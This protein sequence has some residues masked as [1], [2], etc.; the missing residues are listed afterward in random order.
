MKC[1]DSIVNDLLRA[2]GLPNAKHKK[3]KELSMGMKQRLGVAKALMG[4]PNL[5]L[6][7]EPANG[8]DQ[9]LI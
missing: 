5:L 7:D 3:F 4:N 9:D 6:L 1:N 2:V 8:L